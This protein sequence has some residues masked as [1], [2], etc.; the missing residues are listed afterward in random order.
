[1]KKILT[2]ILISC[3]CNS[4]SQFSQTAIISNLQSP[5][6]FDWMPNG[7]YLITLKGTGSS[8]STNAKIQVYSSTGTFLNTFYDLSDSTN[9]DFER[10]VL[11]ICVDPSFNNNHFVYVYYNHN[12]NGDERIRIVKFTESGNAG[13]NPQLILD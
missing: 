9:S 8:P 1:M 6:A 4:Y 7:N 11:G 3:F 13:T 2:F 5:V 10:G 12:Y